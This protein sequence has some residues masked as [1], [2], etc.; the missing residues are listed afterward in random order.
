MKR[1]MTSSMQ[2]TLRALRE[3]GYQPAI[4]ERFNPYAGKFGQREDAYGIF[5]IIAYGNGRIVGVQACGSD[6]ASHDRKILESEHTMGWLKN[7]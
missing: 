4:V 2:R 5:D 7:T 6:F 3:L 1:N